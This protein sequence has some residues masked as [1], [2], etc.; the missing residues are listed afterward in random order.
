MNIDFHAHIL[1]GAD[2]GSDGL[3]TS[4]RQ[5]ELAR[6]AG[7]DCVVATPHFYPTED[8]VRRFLDRRANAADMLRSHL[9]GDVPQIRIGA[10][11]TLCAGMDHMEGIEALCIAGTK[12]L[13]IELPRC[14][15]R[16]ELLE[17][18]ENLRSR[19]GLTIVLAHIDRYDNKAVDALLDAGFLFQLNA[20]A[21]V[22]RFGR[23]RWRA[24]LQS[25]GCAGIGSDIHGTK[26]GYSNFTR[27]REIYN[28]QWDTIM[29]FSRR[30]LSE[31]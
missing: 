14:D 24:L 12:V 20:D 2:H 23:G 4:L 17:S 31:T 7:I 21:I 26:I 9:S 27:A 16:P 30:L 13:L 3:K 19:C 8:T 1:P 22:R 28:D 15:L 10:E 25:G 6:L 11:V 29:Q 18:L 5:L